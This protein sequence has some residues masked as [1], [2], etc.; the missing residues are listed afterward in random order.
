[1]LGAIAVSR[2]VHECAAALR[3]AGT[4]WAVKAL[5]D[6]VGGPV[7]AFND[8]HDPA[9]EF[10]AAAFPARVR[11]WWLRRRAIRTLTRAAR[12]ARATGAQA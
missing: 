1:M 12:R 11:A 7:A 9:A 6:A 3:L 4:D 8:G 10:L 5:Q 2:G